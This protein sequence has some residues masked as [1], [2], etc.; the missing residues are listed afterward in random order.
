MT[1]QPAFGTDR[2]RALVA[3]LREMRD[4]HPVWQDGQGLWNVFR[5]ADVQRVMTDPTTFS[6]D[7]TR[8]VPSMSHLQR[9]T[10]TRMDPP[11][12]HKLRRLISHS[13]T[14][15]RVAGL[16]PRITAI[17]TQLLD[18]LVGAE[19][20]DLVGAFTYPLPVIVIAELLGVPTSDRKLFHEWADH[21]LGVARTN[22][23]TEEFAKIVEEGMR[24]M[25]AYLLAHCRER[26]L[27]PRDDL[28]SDLVTA[29]V[30]G[31][32]L[33]DEEV[34]NFSRLLLLAGHITTTLLLGNT[35]LCFDENPQSASDV[36]AAHGLIPSA[37]EEVLRYR[38]PFPMMARVSTRDV[39][40]AGTTIPVNQMVLVWLL[41]ANHDERQFAEPERFDVHRASND[42]VA[43]GHGIHFCMGAPLA[44]L[45]GRIAVELLLTRLA[46]IRITP[47][48][49]LEFYPTVFGA[50]ALPLTVRWA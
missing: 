46:D 4:E 25:D 23:R 5:Y 17:A 29:E 35:V 26:R 45:E 47:G 42:H 9:G 18:D 32:R 40:I 38:S 7:T 48:D 49:P 6:S 28:I 36:R 41:G 34:V 2:G 44:R 50:K 8:L 13:F 11:A 19:Q 39:E 31:E 14:P 33:D 15:K 27:T 20:F 24:E 3:W 10:L 30:D 37:L 1:S 16:A 12:H 43:F 21:L 22:F